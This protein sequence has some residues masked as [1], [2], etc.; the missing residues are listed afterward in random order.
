MDAA[1]SHDFIHT[2]FSFTLYSTHSREG[3]GNLLLRHSVTHIPPNS[4][5][6]GGIQGRRFASTTKRINENINLNISCGDRTHNQ[7]HLQAQ[8]VL[9]RHDWQLTG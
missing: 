2:L 7:S 6:G 3:K 4:E 5:G 9:L 8:F 1:F